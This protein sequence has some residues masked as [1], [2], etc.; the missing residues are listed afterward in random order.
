MEIQQP[1]VSVLMTA[2]NREQYIAEAI[3]S[4]LAS[5]YANFELIIVDD[6]STD[7]T[8]EIIQYFAARD[9]RIR[10]FQNEKN[11]GDY[12]NRNKAASYAKGKYLKYID[13]DD[14]ILDFG[15]AYCVEQ[16][17]KYPEAGLGMYYHCEKE[18]VA[19]ECWPSEKI[20][21]EHFFKRPL[22][23][24]GPTGTIIKRQKF[25]QTGRFDTRFG[26]ASDMFFNIRFAARSPIVMLP[27]L[28]VYYR[29]HEGQEINN[30]M[31]YLVFGYLYFK[32]LMK[33]VPLPLQKREVCY[34]YRKMQKR[35]SINLVKYFWRTRDISATKKVMQETNFSMTNLLLSFFK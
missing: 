4:V 29:R 16:M 18:N 12:P 27:T 34:L 22:L 30:R 32:E 21:R 14:K 26:V 17:E 7:K 24:M 8:F 1:I 15:L 35:H 25:E 20:V 31:G 9:N 3:E 10:L 2:Y 6:C 5:T 28:F 13:S 19:A 23:S 11:L 33:Q